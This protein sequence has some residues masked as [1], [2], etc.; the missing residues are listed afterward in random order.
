MHLVALRMM[1]LIGVADYA[2]RR[3]REA[4][5]KHAL[6]SVRPEFYACKCDEIFLKHFGYLH[7]GD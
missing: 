7:I 1:Y 3:L 5:I 6:L 2:D 4:K